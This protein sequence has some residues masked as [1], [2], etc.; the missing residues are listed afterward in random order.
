MPSVDNWF[1]RK[2]SS[3]MHMPTCIVIMEKQHSA[4]KGLVSFPD[5]RLPRGMHKEDATQQPRGMHACMG[6][7]MN[8]NYWIIIIIIKY[9]AI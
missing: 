4:A 7:L 2:A 9:L 8:T 6:G 3:G 1:V 5:Q